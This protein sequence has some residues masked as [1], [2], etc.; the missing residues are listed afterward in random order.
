MEIQAMEIQD[1][2]PAGPQSKTSNISYR[3][4]SF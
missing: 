4:N 1:S 3:L 2:V